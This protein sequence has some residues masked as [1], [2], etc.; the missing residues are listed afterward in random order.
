MA[1]QGVPATPSAGCSPDDDIDISTPALVVWGTHHSLSE[2]TFDARRVGST[3]DAFLKLRTTVLLKASAPRKTPVFLFIHPER[4]RALRLGGFEADHKVHQE[5][6]C[7]RLGTDVACLLFI[8]SR[9]ADLVGPKESD[10]IPKNKGSGDTLDSLRCLARQDDFAIY[11]PRKALSQARLVSLCEAAS[12]GALKS[13]ARQ[14]DLTSLYRGKGGR[15]ITQLDTPDDAA[16]GPSSPPSYDELGPSPPL[17]PLDASFGR[18][19]MFLAIAFC[20]TG[21]T[22]A[23][24]HAS[25]K[26]RRDSSDDVGS[27]R[28]DPVDVERMCRKIVEEQKVEMLK[29]VEEQQNKLYERLLADLKPYIGQE[30]DKLET[31]IMEH[32][33]E[34]AGKQAEEQDEHLEQRLEEVKDEVSD[35]IES[36]VG[37]VDEKVEDEFYGLRLRLEDFIREEITDAEERIVEHLENSATVSLSFG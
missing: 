26:R 9:P 27:R 30:L 16:P 14:A 2:A 33:E 15:V 17:A 20:L 8:L 12:S 28:Q 36:R 25:K 18:T 35:A 32:V 24:G 7:R 4:V 31:R 13:I 37:D 22:Q 29:L 6:A 1:D 3:A 10:L 23:P 19:Q 11:F 21:L 34:R 5:E